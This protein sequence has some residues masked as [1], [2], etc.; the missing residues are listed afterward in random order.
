MIKWFKRSSDGIG[1]AEMIGPYRITE[2]L[3]R[4]GMGVVYETEPA[5][6]KGSVHT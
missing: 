6:P 4:G 5:R 1:E 3:G 2:V